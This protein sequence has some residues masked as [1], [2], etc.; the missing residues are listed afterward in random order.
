MGNTKVTDSGAGRHTN[1]EQLHSPLFGSLASYV[2][3]WAS[4]VHGNTNQIPVSQLK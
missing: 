4:I 3:S 2:P 1:Q